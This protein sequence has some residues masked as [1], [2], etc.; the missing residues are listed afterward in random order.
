MQSN[1]P[2]V[3]IQCATVSLLPPPRFH[4]AQVPRGIQLFLSPESFTCLAEF[5]IAEATETWSQLMNL[6]E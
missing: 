5:K 3:R 1:T 2:N 4:R 6:S